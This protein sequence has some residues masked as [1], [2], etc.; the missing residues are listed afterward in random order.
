MK[1]LTTMAASNGSTC[2]ILMTEPARRRRTR[3]VLDDV[4]IERVRQFAKWGDQL[5][6]DGTSERFIGKANWHREAC[7][8]HFREG[9]GTWKDVLLE[10]VYEA[11]AEE[12]WPKLRAELIQVAAV[13]VSWIEDGDG[14]CAN[15][16]CQACEEAAEGYE[17]D[18]Q[19]HACHPH[20]KD[21]SA[22]A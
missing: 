20:P 13:A 21:S 10:E 1:S 9:V 15:R 12:E 8:L 3:R 18:P 11:M 6:P 5:N 17:T 4:A 16:R 7:Q 22:A 14:R 2:V 19:E